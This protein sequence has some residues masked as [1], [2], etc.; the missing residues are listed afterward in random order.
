MV[1]LARDGA[2]EIPEFSFHKRTRM[3]MEDNA[4]FENDD[5]IDE[6][7]SKIDLMHPPRN[8]IE[9][10]YSQYFFVTGIRIPF[11]LSSTKKYCE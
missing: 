6:P 7:Q 11:S 5:L 9:R 10:N 3:R 8:I 1:D 2:Q 4:N